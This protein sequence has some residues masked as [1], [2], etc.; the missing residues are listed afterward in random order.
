MEEKNV[1]DKCP[2]CAEGKF[3]KSPKTGKVFC[4]KKCWLSS[5]SSPQPF[6]G[7]GVDMNQ[8]VT[9]TQYN[10]VLD[11]QR[12]AFKMMDDRIKKLESLL[13]N[14]LGMVDE[15]SIPIVGEK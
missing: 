11:N 15:L 3:V 2:N 4:D 9:L 8:F 6:G 14:E 7:H 1:G 12:V 13:A 5:Q 10:A